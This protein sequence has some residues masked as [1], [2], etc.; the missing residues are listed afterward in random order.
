MSKHVSF[1]AEHLSSHDIGKRIQVITVDGAKITD[2]LT[3]I[4]A[5]DRNGV[6]ELYLTFAS[7]NSVA[8]SMSGGA[9][10]VNPLQYVKRMDDEA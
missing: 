1:P 8:Y 9:F 10:Q 2:T 3:R 6:T 7:V 5:E 4:V